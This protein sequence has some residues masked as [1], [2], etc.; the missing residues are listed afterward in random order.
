MNIEL[1]KDLICVKMY[2]G[3]TFSHYKLLLEL[4]MESEKDLQDINDF[5]FG[6]S[7]IMDGIL[8]LTQ[9]ELEAKSKEGL[10]WVYED[11]DRLKD[12]LKN[13]LN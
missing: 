5:V 9:K 4:F 1:R 13:L 8:F 3:S 2:I 12:K 11:S 7:T 6:F 10:D